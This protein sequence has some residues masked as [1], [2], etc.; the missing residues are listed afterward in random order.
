MPGVER[1]AVDAA[2]LKQMAQQV[3]PEEVQLYYQ[4]GV[5]GKRDI[6]EAP[7]LRSGFEMVLLRMLAF[8]PGD[9]GSHVEPAVARSR[10]VRGQRSSSSSRQ[11]SPLQDLDIQQTRPQYSA[12]AQQPT[13]QLG[14]AAVP[15]SADEWSQIV[16]SL[17]LGGL[18]RQLAANCALKSI[19]A[20][21][22]CLTLQERHR[23]L[24]SEMAEQRL[25]EALQGHFSSSVS[26][27]IEIDEPGGDTP[28]QQQAL[29]DE[30][31]VVDARTQMAQDPFV[32]A[33][34][35]QLDATLLEE[36]VKPV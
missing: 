4:I 29:A 9:A 30:Q 12:A 3:T 31:K 27:R 17:E 28:A 15:A 35:Q 36:T 11:P 22:V 16:A 19:D 1:E 14:T 20:Q 33:A 6:M 2:R 10:E 32:K 26:L 18:S 7:D 24:K 23:A 5:S 21:Q 25:L 13:G 8:R 34:V